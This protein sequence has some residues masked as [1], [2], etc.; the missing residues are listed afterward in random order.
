MGRRALRSDADLTTVLP[1]QMS[2]LE[3]GLD[4]QW[5]SPALV[6]RTRPFYHPL[7]EKLGLPPRRV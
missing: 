7:S 5:R 6:K 4:A 3:P 2:S 1:A